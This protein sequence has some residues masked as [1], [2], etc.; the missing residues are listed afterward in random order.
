MGLLAARIIVNGE[1]FTGNR[2]H[3]KSKSGEKRRSVNLIK[4]KI[5]AR[6]SNETQAAASKSGEKNFQG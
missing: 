4:I 3:S 1:V 2:F 6:V 5:A